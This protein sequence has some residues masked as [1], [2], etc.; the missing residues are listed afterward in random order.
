[1]PRSPCCENFLYYFKAAARGR[2]RRR[3][4]RHSRA[5]ADAPARLASTPVGWR[6][7]LSR[8]GPRLRTARRSPGAAA[9]L[10]REPSR[11]PSS[12]YS[13][14]A[15]ASPIRKQAYG[16]PPLV[17]SAAPFTRRRPAT[18]GWRA[19]GK[20]APGRLVSASS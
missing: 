17:K 18:A 3:H 13:G 9:D 15:E 5:P 19:E 10:T 16:P 7:N 1:M 14:Q 2:S 4:G 12:G 8:S 6:G 20:Q 11:R